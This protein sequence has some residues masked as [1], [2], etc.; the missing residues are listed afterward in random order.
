MRVFMIKLKSIFFIYFFIDCSCIG[1]GDSGG[2][3]M[4]GNNV[5]GIVSWGVGAYRDRSLLMSQQNNWKQIF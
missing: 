1:Q 2:G 4:C 5:A 3:L